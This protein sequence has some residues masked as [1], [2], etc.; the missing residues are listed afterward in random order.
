MATL[1]TYLGFRLA[2]KCRLSIAGTVVRALH[3]L[4]TVTDLLLQNVAELL[5]D[6]FSRVRPLK[7]NLD[8]RSES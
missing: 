3:T 2:H 5:A 1:T 8:H 6:R 4:L 7:R